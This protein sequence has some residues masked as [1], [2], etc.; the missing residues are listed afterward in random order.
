MDSKCVAHEVL[1]IALLYPEKQ[2]RIDKLPDVYYSE[3]GQTIIN[4][5]IRSLAHNRLEKKEKGA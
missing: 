5:I 2:N 4:N 3:S 1:C